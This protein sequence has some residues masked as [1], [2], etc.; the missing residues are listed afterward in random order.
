VKDTYKKDTFGR[1]RHSGIEYARV[2]W[3]EYAQ[4]YLGTGEVKKYAVN[5]TPLRTNKPKFTV[6]KGDKNE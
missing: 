1:T 3:V 6:I 4:A 5:H 2:A